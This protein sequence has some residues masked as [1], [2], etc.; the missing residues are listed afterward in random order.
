[1]NFDGVVFPGQGTQAIRMGKDFVENYTE[2]KETFEIASQ[3]LNF[4]VY[5]ICQNN[6]DKLS[7]T[8]YTQPCILTL[9][10]AI[11][12]VLHKYFHFSPKF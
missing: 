3:A 8:Q 2:A 9:E 11:F 4:D 10:I 12:R 1:M 7:N 5:E 6:E